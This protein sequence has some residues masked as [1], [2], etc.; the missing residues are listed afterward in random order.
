M[1]AVVQTSQERDSIWE[2]LGP[3]AFQEKDFI[4]EGLGPLASQEKDFIRKDLGPLAS[5]EKDFIWEGLGPL[6]SKEKD[7]IG[8]ELY[9][10][11]SVPVV[12]RKIFL[13]MSSG[14]GISYV[15]DIR[16]WD[17]PDI[18]RLCALWHFYSISIFLVKNL[19]DCGVYLQFTFLKRVIG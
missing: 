3:L 13:L 2:H 15:N 1:R 6:A 4:W 19:L 11:K 17:T 16:L 5:Q 9:C 14:P 8:S 12:P 10:E 18:L 7:L